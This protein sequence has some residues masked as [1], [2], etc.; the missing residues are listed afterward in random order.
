VTE[1]RTIDVLAIG[2]I[3]ADL[4]LTVG[5]LPS[6]DEKVM[7]TLV[8]WMAGGPAANSA[9]AASR[10]GL[11]V[12]ALAMLGDDRSGQIAIDGYAEFG[13]DTSLIE[14]VPGA[15]SPFTVILIPPTGEKAIV[16]VPGTP[17]NYRMDR[18]EQALRRT[19]MM[20]M[21][22]G[23]KAQFLELAALARACGAEVMID[24]ES[25][26]AIDPSSLRQALAAVDIASFNR[27]GFIAAAGV[28]PTAETVQRLLEYGP[29]T[30]V[31]TLGAQG[32]LAATAKGVA[33]R[34]G[35]RVEVV[36]TT[37]AGDTFNA[38]FLSA[39]LDGQTLDQRLRFANAA[40]AL[41]VTGMGPRGYLP[42]RQEVEDFLQTH[43]EE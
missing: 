6:Y 30:I 4:V 21:M 5:E 22:P 14:V 7:G 36:D 18:V 1:E 25:T 10:L 12:T 23:A 11:R 17:P 24:V 31:V 19:R 35:H 33:Q 9:C 37:G 34:P 38:A 28:Q 26:V 3:D 20:Y 16:V 41:S 8:G 39:T 27:D 13:V 40:A 32:A 2:G 29:H 42:T 15:T 43:N